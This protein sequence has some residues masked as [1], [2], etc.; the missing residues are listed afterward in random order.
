VQGLAVDALGDG[1]HQ[2]LFNRRSSRYPQRMAIQISF[3]NKMIGSEDSYEFLLALVGNA[4]EFYVA[5]S[6]EKNCVGLDIVFPSPTLARNSFVR[7][8]L[9]FVSST[10]DLV[11]E[12]SAS[13]QS[14]PSKTRINTITSTRP[15]PPP[16]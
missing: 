6:D 12:R 2:G 1:R 8:G 15:S 11:L 16:P 10:K 7:I 3:A 9:F 5:L 4:G 14:L 13:V